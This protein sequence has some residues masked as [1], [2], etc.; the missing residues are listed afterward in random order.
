M[1]RGNDDVASFDGARDVPRR[2]HIADDDVGAEAFGALRV[3]REHAHVTA[4]VD[5]GAHDVAPQRAGAPGDE[6][7]APSTDAAASDAELASLLRE[8]EA[9]RLARMTRNARVL[10]KRGFLREG[11]TVAAARDLMWT[12]VAPEL[13]DLLVVRR[14]WTPKRY[15][16]LLAETM[17]AAFL[18]VT[19]R[20]S[21]S[22][23]RPR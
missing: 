18:P 2:A 17:I 10:A 19:S 6:D 12:L 13:Y 5:E 11:V 8:I 4:A 16:A 14:G 23:R 3:A 20:G 1:D 22:A 21:G 7:H 15:G 9:E